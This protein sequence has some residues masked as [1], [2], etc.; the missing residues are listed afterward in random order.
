MSNIKDKPYVTYLLLAA[1][2]VVFGLMSVMGG[3]ENPV[4]LVE[5]GAKY[6][7]LIRAGQYW[8]LVTPIFIHIGFTHILMNGI[9]LYFI[10]QYVEQ[11]FG[12]WRFTI[13]FFVSGIVGNL[14]SFAFNSGLSAGASTA[15]FGLFGAFLMLGESFSKN[16]AIVSMAK[17]FLLF[18]VLNI[19]TDI[20]VSGIDIAGHIGGLVG[21]FLIAYVTGV[22]FSKTSRVK[23]VI[24]AIMLVVIVFVLY[25]IGMQAK[26]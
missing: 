17:T 22:G 20:F 11:L 18:I 2:V 16:P 8:R 6:N 14:G 10:G 4:T 23:R 5:F 21:G 26:F 19:G 7:P 24:A 15:I 3:T 12:H 25:T 13:I 1:M 9:T